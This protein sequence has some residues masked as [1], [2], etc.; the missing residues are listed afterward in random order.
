M[1]INSFSDEYSFLSNFYLS[2][3]YIDGVMYPSV[4]HYYQSMKFTG[5]ARQVVLATATPAIAKKMARSL[6]AD[7]FIDNWDDIKVGV[8]RTALRAKFAPGSTLAEMLLNTGDANLVEGNT[9]HDNFW[10]D[11]T[12]DA[13]VIVT[14]ENMLGELLM[15]IR[16]EL[17]DNSYT[18]S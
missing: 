11:C 12:C 16:A 17:R 18:T 10:G 6:P 4:E 7:L 13:C 8:M 5:W 1:K 3:F 2:V 15:E 9:W 14:G